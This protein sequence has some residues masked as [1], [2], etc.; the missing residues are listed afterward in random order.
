M[1]VRRCQLESNGLRP[2]CLLASRLLGTV[3]ALAGIFQRAHS[4]GL[5]NNTSS[6]SMYGTD[7][8]PLQ[9]PNCVPRAC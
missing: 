4:W 5:E 7:G 2:E 8:V 3:H 6:E 1:S 9:V